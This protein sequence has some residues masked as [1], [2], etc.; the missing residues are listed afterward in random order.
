[1]LESIYIYFK[2]IKLIE[3]DRD[4][5]IDLFFHDPIRSDRDRDC[6]LIGSASHP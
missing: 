6:D 1:M 5:S 2:K 3:R 4:H